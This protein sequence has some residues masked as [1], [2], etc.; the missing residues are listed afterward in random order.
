MNDE[1]LVTLM[2]E[3]ERI[4]NS[5]PLTKSS[6]DPKD[7]DV[8]TPNKLLLLKNDRALPYGVYDPKD[9]YVN[10]WWKQAQRLSNLFWKR[11]LREY[12]PT[13][14]QRQKWVSLKDNLQI[15][16]IVLVMDERLPR[17]Q[18]PLGR[19]QKT[20]PDRNGNVRSVEVLS[21]G[22]LKTRPIS[23]VCLL[24]ASTLKINE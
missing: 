11:W 19:I 1:T 21:N 12:L 7:E 6:C 24:E 5:R 4:M 9:E 16:D 8:L 3:V 15:G 14:Q 18:W 23:K 22:S 17:G 2:A 10:R 20:R 13:L